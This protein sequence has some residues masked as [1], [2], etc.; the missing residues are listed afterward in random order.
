M[1]FWSRILFL[2][3]LLG[4]FLVGCGGG[5]SPLEPAPEKVVFYAPLVPMSPGDLV[6]NDYH[7]TY[8][9]RTYD[10]GET[11][12]HWRVAGIGQGHVLDYFWIEIP[13]C[14]GEPVRWEPEDESRLHTNGE[15]DLYGVKWTR[16]ISPVDLEGQTYSITFAGDVAEGT[17][18]ALVNG[19]EPTR[20][21]EI[22][23][24]CAG[25]EIAGTVFTDANEDGLRDP[26]T[27]VGL[28]DVI[29]ELID[30]QAQVDTVRTAADG[31]YRFPRPAGT[32]TVRI[33]T[34]GYAD[35]FNPSLGYGF[36]PTSPL[37]LEVTIGP[38]ALDVDF[39]FIVDADQIAQDLEDDIIPTAGEGSIFW[40]QQLQVAEYLE[41]RFEDPPIFKL[42]YGP[43]KMHLFMDVIRHLYL[44]DPY[45]FDPETE[46][47]EAF[48]ILR[49]PPVNEVEELRKQ[50]LISEL[51]YVSDQ[52]IVGPQAALLG[53][54]LAWGEGVLAD[55]LQQNGATA[56]LQKATGPVGRALRLFEAINTGGG[57]AI[58]D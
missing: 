49:T 34:V 30:A 53:P 25:Y 45:V 43:V 16:T 51:N 35:A 29:V 18:R 10:D 8:E 7:V 46:F 54:L 32:Y 42:Y 56:P 33:D 57:G 20:M 37:E 23:G 52:G 21:G 44:A 6:I 19:A 40:K 9:G 39:G 50:L 28:G 36:L 27:D 3:P 26:A 24:P 31:S 58:D 12:F 48:A 11:T 1:R 13:E 38:D 14:A 17:V 15:F 55:A 5:E 47:L 2:L 22:T 41:H 4:L